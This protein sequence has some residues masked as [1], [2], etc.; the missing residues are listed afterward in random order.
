[1]LN[2][3]EHTCANLGALA[4]LEVFSKCLTAA[5]PL[6]L[7]FL[8]KWHPSVFTTLPLPNFW[9]T[10]RRKKKPGSLHLNSLAF[11]FFGL[12]LLLLFCDYPQRAFSSAALFSFFFVFKVFIHFDF[13]LQFLRVFNLSSTASL[14]P[15]A[16]LRN[17]NTTCSEGGVNY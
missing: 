2:T 13:I 4:G 3:H 16:A 9:R 14:F 1:M 7:S 15:P 5:L 12:F 10:K 6:S 11:F 17:A 8:T